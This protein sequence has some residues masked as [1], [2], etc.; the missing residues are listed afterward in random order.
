MC[1]KVISKVTKNQG[2]TLSIENRF[3][4]KPRGKG[5]GVNLAPPPRKIRVEKRRQE[6]SIPEAECTK[7]VFKIQPPISGVNFSNNIPIR[8][9]RVN[10]SKTEH[11]KTFETS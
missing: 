1:F 10:M 9:A 11:D 4:K 5:G 2:S 8:Q 6:S 3:F 7:G